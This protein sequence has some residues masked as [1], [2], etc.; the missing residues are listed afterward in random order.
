MSTTAAGSTH[1]EPA[2]ALEQPGV[3]EPAVPSPA[4][5]LRR[6]ARHRTALGVLAI[7]TLGLA[8]AS[9][10]QDPGP[11]P[12]AHFALVQSLSKGTAEIGPGV[13]VDSAYIDGKYFANKAP[14]LAFTLLP[15]YLG[16]R[17]A[18]LQQTPATDSGDGYRHRLWQMTLVGAVLPA[19]ALMLLM[20]VAVDVVWPGYGS[21]TAILLGAGTML[22]PF[23]TLLFGHMLSATLGF[24]AFVVLLLERQRAPS[25]WR[26]GVAGLLAGLA[27][28]VEYPLAIVALVLLG[29]VAAGSQNLRRGASY[30]SGCLIGV[31]PLAAY[32]TWAF[33]SPT[34]L[35]YTNVLNAPSGSGPPTLGGGNSTG[36][37][38][39][40]LPDPRSALSLLFSEKGLL[41]VTPL[42]IA[43]LFG[44]P[45]LWRSGRRAEAAVCTAVPVLFLAYNASYYLPFGGQGPGPRF[46]VPAL[47]FL[48]LPLAAA[49]TRRLLTVLVVGLL[50]VGVMTL[51]TVTA[52]LI[53]GADHSIA[54]W[55]GLLARG[56]VM[57]T[58][59]SPNGWQAIVPLAVLLAAAFGFALMSAAPSR[60]A[61]RPT[62]LDALVVPAW[63]L[64][65]LAAPKLLPADAEHGTTAGTL[66]VVCLVV[67]L[68]TA[69][70]LVGR[71]GPAVAAAVLPLVVLVLPAV[72]TRQK[73]SLLVAAATVCVVAVAARSRSASPTR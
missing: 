46:L 47:P 48:A 68:A 49:L 30:A 7:A 65:A 55:A 33:G 14:G 53:T 31:V 57:S 40:A 66:A 4:D 67:A 1:L 15:A 8:A 19:V 34:T 13:T 3:L 72:Y 61:F 45:A 71:R 54:S 56:D 32:N 63:A 16:L 51:A 58:A 6:I 5:G 28:V 29:Y 18:G 73:V 17:A 12:V 62:A 38:G 44:L 41:V 52:P 25:A 24:A 43:A 35:S 69:L 42:C 11:T 64:M 27:V 37:Y 59:L 70:A 26:A 60:E 39:V 10:Q 2:P 21:L 20:L 23:A 22:L 9:L 50:S 36:F